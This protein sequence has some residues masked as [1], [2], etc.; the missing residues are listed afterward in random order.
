[1]IGLADAVDSVGRVVPIHDDGNF[2][3]VGEVDKCFIAV[4]RGEVE[5]GQEIGPQDGLTD[6]G[7]DE[8]KVEDTVGYTDLAVC[9]TVARYF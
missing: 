6:I 5:S 9:K 2:G 3:T 4:V 8:R 1:M 7:D